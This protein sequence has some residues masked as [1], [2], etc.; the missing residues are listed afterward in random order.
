MGSKYLVK[1]PTGWYSYR[2]RIP[3]RLQNVLGKREFKQRLETKDETTALVRLGQVNT[4]ACSELKAAEMLLGDTKPSTSVE[5]LAAAREFLLRENLHP[6]QKP[7]LP[8]DHTDEQLEQFQKDRED[9]LDRQQVFLDFYQDSQI[10]E[11][12]WTPKYKKDDP[13][14]VWQASAS[15]M[16]GQAT[17]SA[18]IT[19]QEAVE[20]YFPVNKQDKRRDPHDQHKFETKTRNL[21]DKFA[22]FIGGGDTKL[23]DITRATARAYLDTYRQGSKPAKEGTIGRYSS[24]IGAVFNTARK[25]FM[26]ATIANPFEGLR[27]SAAEHDDATKR[28]SFTPDEL[29]LYEQAVR[30]KAQPELQLIGLLMIYTGCR[31][32]EASGLEV[33]DID[34]F[35]NTPH[36]KFRDNQF[37]R[38][39][40]KGLS[41]SVPLAR[42]LLDAL[43]QYDIPED[44]KAPLFGKYAPRS[45]A[46]NV[47]NQLNSLIR[48]DLKLSEPQLVAYSTRHTFKTRAKAARVDDPVIDYLQGHK[49]EYSTRIAQKYSD[50]LLPE[51]FQEDLGRILATKQWAVLKE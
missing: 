7:T 17:A 46:D 27:N 21:F 15:I 33:R 20:T 3:A 6:D 44:A 25:E 2:R 51:V 45:A 13:K 28:R 5:T 30:A 48:Y 49:S 37:R 9:W 1:S 43:R 47:S 31:T 14:D 16:S 41:R 36:V 4:K 40:K 22:S 12:G 10:V 11:D 26:D 34:I 50:G 19:W 18:E 35:S 39:D 42:P 23:K 29:A 8:A 32:S 38:L 24:Q